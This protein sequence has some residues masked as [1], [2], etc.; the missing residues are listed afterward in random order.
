VETEKIVASQANEDVTW[1]S[2]QGLGSKKPEALK[3]QAR[4]VLPDSED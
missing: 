1:I 3:V 2:E 4:A